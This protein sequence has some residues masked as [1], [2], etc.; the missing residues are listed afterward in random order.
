MV[1]ADIFAAK[2]PVKSKGEVGDGAIEDLLVGES[3]VGK[4]STDQCCRA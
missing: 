4:K 1:P 3:R 2:V